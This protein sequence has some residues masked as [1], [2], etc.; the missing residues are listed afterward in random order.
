[1]GLGNGHKVEGDEGETE[2]T[3]RCCFN[4]G[5]RIVGISGD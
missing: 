4:H 2:R 1:M 5:F 3:D